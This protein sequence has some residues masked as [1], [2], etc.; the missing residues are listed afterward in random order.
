MYPPAKWGEGYKGNRIL[1]FPLPEEYTLDGNTPLDKT[2][3]KHLTKALQKLDARTQTQNGPQRWKDRLPVDEN[4]WK[5]LARIYTSSM[6][7]ARD[8]Y[9]H[10]QHITH[11]RIGT[12]NRFPGRD[13]TCR[14]C[15]QSHESST[16]LGTCPALDDI[17]DMIHELTEYHPTQ[18]VSTSTDQAVD[19]LFILPNTNSPH[20]RE[21]LY[22][23]AW[24][25]IL[26]DFYRVH[27]D[28]TTFDS[29]Q[30]KKRIL[31]RYTTLV[32]AAHFGN[33]TD[34]ARRAQADM[35]R[36]PKKRID[37]NDFRPLYDVIDNETLAPSHTLKI[38][39]QKL[40][41]EHILV[42][43]NKEHASDQG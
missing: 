15:K 1:E 41:I 30:I 29:K 9:L 6:I 20:S 11:R 31:T 14:L 39:T 32:K 26:T 38:A 40:E 19:R 16:H 17:F 5:H 23:L 34:A 8:S 42:Q 36:Q 35:G 27:F 4:T 10:F 13:P 22:I 7:T 37:T 43:D 33:S 12:H 24:R 3:V 18:H 25:Y 2:E 21:I 28:N